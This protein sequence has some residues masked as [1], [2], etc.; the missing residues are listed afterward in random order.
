M[1]SPLSVLKPSLQTSLSVGPASPARRGRR[2]RPADPPGPFARSAGS[3]GSPAISKQG[4]PRL[5]ISG[6]R[7]LQP[8]I[9]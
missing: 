6:S 7:E 4:D 1:A 2:D 8:Q 5:Q 9:R 3:G